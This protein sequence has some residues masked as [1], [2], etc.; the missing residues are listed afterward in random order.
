MIEKNLRTL[1]G[2]KDR[3]D[4]SAQATCQSSIPVVD[5]RKGI[6]VSSNNF[7]LKNEMTWNSQKFDESRS[8]EENNITRHLTI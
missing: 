7:R 2:P 3:K 4:S 8:E 5:V 6:A 1:K